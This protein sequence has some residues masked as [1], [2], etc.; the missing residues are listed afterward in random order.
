MTPLFY[1]KKRGSC[2]AEDRERKSAKVNLTFEAPGTLK[3][4]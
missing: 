4:W 2:A 3:R 1:K